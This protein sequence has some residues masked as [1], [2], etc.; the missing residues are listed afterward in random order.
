MR[1]QTFKLNNTYLAG[2]HNKSNW[3]HFTNNV[4]LIF[5]ECGF[6]WGGDLFQ[7]LISSKLDFLR[8]ALIGNGCVIFLW[9]GR[10]INQATWWS[11]YLN[12]RGFHWWYRVRRSI[13]RAL[14]W[15]MQRLSGHTRLGTVPVMNFLNWLSVKTVSVQIS[16]PYTS[17]SLVDSS[18]RPKH[19]NPRMAHWPPNRNSKWSTD[20][21]LPGFQG[22]VLSISLHRNSKTSGRCDRRL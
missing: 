8:F 18:A 1:Q 7:V 4:Y 13:S 3:T 15:T 17:C 9:V 6:K 16:A 14:I 11:R 22:V 19:H 21:R 5:L 12:G 10:R 2:L 20:Q